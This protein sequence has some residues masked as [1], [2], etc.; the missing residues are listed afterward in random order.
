[1]QPR[2]LIKIL[3][4]KPQVVAELLLVPVRVFIGGGGAE[5]IG[6]PTPDNLVRGVGDGARG[7]EVVGVDVVGG[8]GREDGHGGVAEVDDLLDH[9]GGAVIFAQQ[10]TLFVVDE[11]VGAGADASAGFHDALAQAV[12]GVGVALGAIGD[13]GQ[14]TSGVVGEGVCAVGSEVA[15]GVVGVAFGCASALADEAVAGGGDDVIGD[16]AALGQPGAVAVGVVLV[17]GGRPGGVGVAGEPVYGVIAVAVR[18]G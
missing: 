7:V 8:G 9:S 11:A 6:I 5:G 14:S 16:G 18:A 4:R 1:M 13:L 3:P 10:M 2:L 17:A 12:E 15:G